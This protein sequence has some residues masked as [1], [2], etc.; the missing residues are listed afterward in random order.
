MVSTSCSDM[1]PPLIDCPR[2]NPTPVRAALQG[3][4]GASAEPG[5]LARGL[6]AQIGLE[7]LG[8]GVPQGDDV[9]DLPL[10]LQAA[11]PSAAA[12]PEQDQIAPVAEVVDLAWSPIDR[13][14]R[15]ERLAVGC[16]QALV[17]VQ[18][19]RRPRH[20]AALNQH[21]IGVPARLD[22]A[23]AL[24][25]AHLRPLIG[26]L[27]EPDPELERSRMHW[28]GVSP[29]SPGENFRRR[30]LRSGSESLPYQE[31]IRRGR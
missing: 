6:P 10:E 12:R 26:D 8:L 16:H 27:V 3:L 13:L 28:R 15:L 30:S 11:A 24:L 1:A 2:A 14:P 25:R 17:A 21:Q 23:P 4:A 9:G 31:R 29:L 5:R 18:L 20:L 7:P 19:P 22:R